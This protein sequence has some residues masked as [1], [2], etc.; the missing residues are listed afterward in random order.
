MTL[1]EYKNWALRLKKENEALKEE[2]IRIRQTH[3]SHET[4]KLLTK[5]YEDRLAEQENIIKSD[6]HELSCLHDLLAK[7][8]PRR[9]EEELD[10]R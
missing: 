2:N 8:D 7:H 10:E 9:E 6:H 4:V 3:V 1:E 5:H